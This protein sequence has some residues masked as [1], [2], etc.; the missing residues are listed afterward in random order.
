MPGVEQRVEPALKAVRDHHRITA[1]EGGDQE[2]GDVTQARDV[3]RAGALGGQA[4]GKLEYEQARGQDVL[5]QRV[6]LG[7]VAGVLQERRQEL[8]GAGL[9]KVGH[10]HALAVAH[11]DQARLLQ[12]AHRLAQRVAMV[13]YCAASSR[14]PGN[15]SL[16]LSTPF[17]I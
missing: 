1:L 9:A 11:G 10:G 16:G 7:G 3:V 5:E 2:L 14:S 8:H 6:D 4:R 12:H 17:K 15:R 13:P